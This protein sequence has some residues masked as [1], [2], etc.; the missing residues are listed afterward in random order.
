M[1]ARRLTTLLLTMLAGCAAD[2][3]ATRPAP[4]EVGILAI[5]DFHGNIQ[6]PHLAITAPDGTTAVPAGGAAYLASAIATLRRA[7]PN[8][9]TVSAGDMTGASP[10]PSSIFLDEP[11]IAA[12]NAIGVDLNAVGNHEFDRG[13]TELLRL[14]NGG[15]GRN[16]TPLPCQIDRNFTGARFRYLAGNTITASGESLLP[17]TAIRRFGRGSRQVTIGFIG[18]TTRTT[19]TLVSPTGIRGIHFADEADTANRLVPALRKAGASTIVLLIHEGAYPRPDTDPDACNGL[20]GPIV[21]IARRLDPAIQVIVS[22]HTHKAYICPGIAGRSLLLTSAGK[23]GTLVTDMTLRFDPRTKRLI[24]STAR[25]V[26]VQGEGFDANGSTIAVSD[27]VPRFAAD[28]AVA[29][30]VDRY[31]TAA[32]PLAKRI[33]G[34]MTRAPAPNDGPPRYHETELGNLVADAQLA[35]MSL[36]ANGS[37]QVAFM[38]PGGLRTDLKVGQDGT[39]TFADAYAVQPFGNILMVRTFTGAQ[40]RAVLEQQ[41]EMAGGKPLILSVA[42]M[43]YAF[44]RSRPVGHRVSDILVQGRPLDDAAPYRVS[45]SNFLAVGGD[46]FTGFSAGQDVDASTVADVDA[47]A[48]YLGRATVTPPAV[49]RIADRTPPAG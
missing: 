7:H 3:V 2:R 17:G 33:V 23:F 35:A 21:E 41:F 26:I 40:L 8:S 39:V 10:L 14:Q 46:G 30:I 37:A 42:G 49:N 38:N 18:L 36:P 25:N 19:A 13:T 32:E 47:L 28:P 5:N 48:D 34:R 22:G 20:S 15:C 6:P 29:T 16:A 45:M 43:T 27:M 4:I 11:T 12:M 24:D 9:I 31:V 1:T 44:D